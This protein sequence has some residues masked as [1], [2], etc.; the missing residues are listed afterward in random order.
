MYC[1]QITESTVVLL[2]KSG[3]R[4][5]HTLTV[6]FTRI[7]AKAVV[8]FIRNCRQLKRFE[9]HVGY[10]DYFNEDPSEDTILKYNMIIKNFKDLLEYSDIRQVFRLKTNYN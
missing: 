10:S 5:I 1:Q 3:L 7:S 2:C 8:Y 9:L 4:Q 6:M